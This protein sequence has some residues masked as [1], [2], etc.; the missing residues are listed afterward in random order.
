MAVQNSF[1]THLMGL[2]SGAKRRKARSGADGP[3]ARKVR[4]PHRGHA[5]V[6]APGE[7]PERRAKGAAE[8]Q[9]W[10]GAGRGVYFGQASSVILHPTCR[11][12][13]WK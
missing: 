1:G 5:C 3:H 13:S 4:R 11:P 9:P 8:T 10:F 6:D 12:P 2:P 7:G